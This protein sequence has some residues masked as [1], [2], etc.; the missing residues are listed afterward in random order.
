MIAQIAA[1][2]IIN[3]SRV[4]WS[5]EPHK[6]QPVAYLTDGSRIDITTSEYLALREARTADD[7][8]EGFNY[9]AF[10]EPVARVAQ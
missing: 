3:K 2:D 5:D 4:A 9:F 1:I 10:A 6:R 8:R 7:Y